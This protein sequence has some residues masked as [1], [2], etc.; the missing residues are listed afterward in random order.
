MSSLRIP[1]DIHQFN[2]VDELQ[3]Q[4]AATLAFAAMEP[5]SSAWPTFDACLGDLLDATRREDSLL[6]AAATP[7]GRLCG[8]LSAFPAYV[9]Q[10]LRL[11][12]IAVAPDLQRRGVG[13]ALLGSLQIAARA[14]GF[15]SVLTSYPDEAGR[16]P[17]AGRNLYPSPLASLSEFDR[18]AAD[19]PLS[20][21]SPLAF[22]LRSGFA[23][24]GVVPDAHGAG[25][26]ELL[27][28]RRL[29]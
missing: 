1:V 26:P 6:L 4:E 11:D 22:F 9:G 10:I 8:L 20:A 21:D 19:S 29:D 24:T 28:A 3:L 18:T 15:H 12:L 7:D 2:P 27:L 25:R 23:L 13:S 17:L 5:V 14:R 16:T